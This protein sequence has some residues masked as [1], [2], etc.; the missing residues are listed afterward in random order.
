MIN[1]LNLSDA[2]DLSVHVW[3]GQLTFQ[4]DLHNFTDPKES[5][6]MKL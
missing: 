6:V 1:S 4:D 2:S 5:S 3:R